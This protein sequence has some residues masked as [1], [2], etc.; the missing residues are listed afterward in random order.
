MSTVKKRSLILVHLC[1][2]VALFVLR[3]ET[4]SEVCGTCHRDI[5]RSYQATGMARSSGAVADIENEGSFAHKLSGVGY[6]IFRQDGAAWFGFDV[7]GMQGRRRLEYFIG[8]GAV[9]RSYL[10]T[11]D[12]FLYQAPV[13]WYAGPARWDLSPGYTQYDHL[14]LTRGIETVCLQCHASRL[15]PAAGT[16]NGYASPPFREGGVSCE[17]CHTSRLRW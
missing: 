10:Y 16:S 7:A 15:Q 12:S 11:I 17:R 3:G 8:S 5:F 2:S 4:G 9:G 14:Y 13:S 6:R 1:S